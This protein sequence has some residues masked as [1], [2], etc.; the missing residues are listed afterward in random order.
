VSE[1]AVPPMMH[2][3]DMDD[4]ALL[5]RV[6][7]ENFEAVSGVHNG[8]GWDGQAFMGGDFDKLWLKTEGEYL[9]RHAQDAKFE[10]LWAH[11]LLPYWD[12][13]LGVRQDFGSGPG[14]TWAAL[15]VSGMA[16]YWVDTEVTLY[17]GESGRTGLR[18]KAEYDLYLTQ[19]LILRPEFKFNAY[20]KPDRARSL[21]AGLS[22]G[23]VE[24]RLRYE[25]SRR[26]APYA[27]FVYARK[28]A[29]TADLERQR[30]SP[31]VD[32]RAVAGLTLFF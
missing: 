6:W 12:S 28:F 29:E 32:H 11:A 2:G 4:G 21:G 8:L 15:G 19:R 13:Q 17:V 31:V 23:Q 5:H 14:R 1:Q 7:L 20:G 22:D 10:A 25:F 30:G 18:L 9:Q 16:P 24:L 26:F 27:G 3:M